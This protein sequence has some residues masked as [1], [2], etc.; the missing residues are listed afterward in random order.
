MSKY[1]TYT[2]VQDGGNGVIYLSAESEQDAEKL[3]ID[4]VKYPD[5]WSLEDVNESETNFY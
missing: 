3:L 4:I 5:D 1:K 2:F